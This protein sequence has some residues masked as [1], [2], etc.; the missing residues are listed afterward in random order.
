MSKDYLSIDISDLRINFVEGRK[1]DDEIFI[2]K[3]FFVENNSGFY[4]DN[5]II[6]PEALGKIIKAAVR[7]NKVKTKKAIVTVS[8]V[9]VEIKEKVIDRVDENLI[10][11]LVKVELLSEEINIDDYELQVILDENARE[12]DELNLKIKVYMM[13]KQFVSSVKATLKASGLVDVYLDL[14]SNALIKLHRHLLNIN[15]MNHEYS[16]SEREDVT[17]MYVDISNQSMQVNV[18]KGY[19]QE[20]YRR[21][22][23]YAYPFLVS[24]EDF[25]DTVIDQ[26][27]DSIETTSRYYKS[28]KVGNYIDEIF[29]YGFNDR[30]EK[31]EHIT[32]LMMDRLMTNVN[33][34]V[35]I[36]G[37]LIGNVDENVNIS[38]Y[39]NAINAL[40]RL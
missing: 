39:L 6:D 26:I 37:V 23:N 18:M 28:T 8:P 1:V 40:I 31:C 21:Q 9:H 32:E 29:V 10:L 27:I 25:S 22:D 19:Q 12:S 4:R 14:S 33:P 36:D 16:V 3:M 15:T 5:E 24:G 30:F 34:L 20:I 38:S 17:V 13:K 2:N 7:K 11:D 35:N